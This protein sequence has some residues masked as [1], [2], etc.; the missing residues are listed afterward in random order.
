MD[1]RCSKWVF[2]YN[3]YP[4]DALDTLDTGFREHGSVR[5]RFQEER[6]DNDTPHLQ[7]VVDFGKSRP[8]LSSLKSWFGDRIHWEKCR[9]WKHS[10]EYCRKDSFPG[11]RSRESGLPRPPRVITELREWQSTLCER[12]RTIPDDR[13]ILWYHDKSGGAGKTALCRYLVSH[14][15]EFGGVLVVIGKAADVKFGVANYLSNGGPLNVVLWNVPRGGVHNFDYSAAEQVK[16]GLFYNTKY[17]SA[18]CF[19]DH[20]HIVIFAN[21]APSEWSLSADRWEIIDL[22]P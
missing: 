15:D 16:D 18:M 3:N 13:T 6:G 11:A 12:L 17:E 19:F 1:T 2:T 9:S 8:R 22:D 14:S 10:V 20:P 4:V 7:G 21:E 5:F